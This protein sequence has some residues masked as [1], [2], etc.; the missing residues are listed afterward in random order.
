MAR[1]QLDTDAYPFPMPVVMVGAMYQGRANFMPAAWVTRVT[2]DPPLLLIALT[3]SHFTSAGIQEHG[4]FG[5]SV[6]SRDLVAAVDYCGLVSGRDQDK[7][8]LFEVFF[9]EL[10]HAPMIAACPLTIACRL[11]R[12][13][14]LSSEWL[15][16]GEIAGAYADEECLTNGQPDPRKVDPIVLTMPDNRYW[17]L[18]EMVGAAWSIGENYAPER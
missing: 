6:P 7:S 3:K 2:T 16:I 15:F 18:G 17:S 12:T 8:G 4:E 14:D 5:L 11:E 9:G 1:I 10:P 13:F